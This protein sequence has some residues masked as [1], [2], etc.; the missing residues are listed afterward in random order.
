MAAGAA[1]ARGM[2]PACRFG[3]SRE[4]EGG[5][6]GSEMRHAIDAH[7]SNLALPHPLGCH[8]MW[9]APQHVLCTPA[10]KKWRGCVADMWLLWLV[11]LTAVWWGAGGGFTSVDPETRRII[12]EANGRTKIK[13]VYVVLEAQYQS[14]LAGGEPCRTLWRGR[15]GVWPGGRRQHCGHGPASAW[16]CSPQCPVPAC[17]PAAVNRINAN[18]KEVCVEIVGYLL[19]ELRDAT[20]YEAFKADVASGALASVFL[21][22]DCDREFGQS[23]GIPRGI[24]LRG[25]AVWH[26]AW[27]VASTTMHKTR[28]APAH[29]PAYSHVGC[30]LLGC[31]QHLHWL[32][33]LH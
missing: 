5:L 16:A 8:P 19:E 4:G 32:P 26:G 15:V 12:P 17:L 25:C 28:R 14:A 10:G 7:H 2:V 29:P 1:C 9:C 23:F 33:N 31:S 27:Q 3:S 13:I 6:R 11:G 18:R 21:K 20:N 22:D 30:Y 24:D